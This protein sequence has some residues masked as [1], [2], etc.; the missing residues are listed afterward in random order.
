MKTEINVIRVI[1]AA[2]K[3]GQAIPKLISFK[4]FVNRNV[5]IAPK[6]KPIEKIINHFKLFG[7]PDIVLKIIYAE[8][9][10]NT[11]KDNKRYFI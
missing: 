8:T 11:A 7:F 2:E 9:L 10:N 3:I 4:D 6:I 5:F 1:L